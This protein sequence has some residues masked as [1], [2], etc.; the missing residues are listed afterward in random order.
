VDHYSRHV[1]AETIPD[2][3]PTSESQSFPDNLSRLNILAVRKMLRISCG[4]TEH[5]C[6]PP[7]LRTQGEFT[8]TAYFG[9]ESG[10]RLET[11]EGMDASVM[12]RLARTS[13]T[14]PRVRSAAT[15]SRTAAENKLVYILQFTR[16]RNSALAIAAQPTTQSCQSRRQL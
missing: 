6:L 7:K 16:K 13:Q 10:G 14:F 3:V 15:P 5:T 1:S 12:L 11:V 9:G 2:T 8:H 4:I